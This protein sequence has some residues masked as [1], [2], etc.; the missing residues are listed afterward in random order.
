MSSISN[1]ES[2][3]SSNTSNISTIPDTDQLTHL[4]NY[5]LLLNYA[6]SD[7]NT[8]KII[9]PM[10]LDTPP[11]RPKSLALSSKT[12]ITK[13]SDSNMKI[14][15]S[16]TSPNHLHPKEK[17]TGS[18]S[19]TMMPISSTDLLGPPFFTGLVPRTL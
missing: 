9:H 11:S 18:D 14:S 12:T 5:N 1:N 13:S 10:E 8:E 15:D 16:D 6:S 7:S 4:N 19:T 3:N 17:P 2:L